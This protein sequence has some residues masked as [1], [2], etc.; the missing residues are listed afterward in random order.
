MKKII[1]TPKSLRKA[2]ADQIWHLK[3]F[4]KEH[5]GN[6]PLIITEFGIPQD[7]GK[8]KAYKSGNFSLQDKA[9][10]RTFLAIE[11]NLASSILWNY[12][13]HNSN[14][15][16]DHWNEED[17]SIYSKDQQ[18]SSS[19]YAGARGKNAFIRPYPIKTAGKP[20]Y[21]HFKMKQKIFEYRFEHDDKIKHPTEIFLPHLH[22]GSGFTIELSD[23]S[24]K[25][26]E[27]NQIIYYYHTKYLTIHSV[28][29]KSKKPPH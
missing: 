25:L 14:A 12:T 24:Y 4:A 8:K 21:L 1:K 23:G 20:L 18:S 11:D 26:D 2:F 19:P 5:M 28:I 15:K 10:H 13:G 6:I 29:I 22:F 17:L 9:L 7:I 27:I 16:G 3:A